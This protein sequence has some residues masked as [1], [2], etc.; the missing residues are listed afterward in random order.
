MRRCT[1]TK[2]DRHV[3]NYSLFHDSSFALLQL[4][5]YMPTVDEPVKSG[6]RVDSCATFSM[7]LK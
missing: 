7:A 4:N 6:K 5:E 1:P 2:S 3:P